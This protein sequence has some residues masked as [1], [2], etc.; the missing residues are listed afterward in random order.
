MTNQK[1]DFEK[2]G[3]YDLRN[4]ARSIGVI[5]PTKFKR[6]ELIQKITAIIMGEE[7][8]KKKTNKGR[9]PKHKLNELSQLDY[10]L[11][12]NLFNNDDPKYK[13][14]QNYTNINIDSECMICENTSSATTNILYDGYYKPFNINYGFVLKKGYL[15][16]Y[17]K[18]NVIILT[19][20]ADK[21]NLKEG[22][23]ISGASS[24]LK[25]KN[26]MLATSI[27]TINNKNAV[28]D[29]I[30]YDQTKL[31]KP[32]TKIKLDSD[33]LID[34]KIIDRLFP[35]AK[36]TRILL[37]FSDKDKVKPVVISMLN[38]LSKLNNI[39][40]FLFTIDDLP[41]EI[42]DISQKCPD[43]QIV[44]YGFDM[45]RSKYI[46]MTK[47]KIRHC[48][49]LVEEGNDV[50]VVCYNTKNCINN[51][52]SNAVIFE[53]LTESGAIKFAQNTM[54]DMFV[55]ARN[56]EHGSLTTIF[57]NSFDED[58]VDICNTNINF[59][60]CPL[61]ETDI[62]TDFFTSFTRNLQDL[63]P[64]KE[65]EKIKKFKCG[66]NKDNLLEKLNQF[67]DNE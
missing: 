37:N 42:Y 7:P 54:K 22:D 13:A 16:D 58:F 23:Y 10:I 5:S 12:N 62:T 66:L 31:V 46:E 20:L 47:V 40:P 1:I 28:T 61:P 14:Y 63:V 6:D 55:V 11:P 45:D 29:R 9:P 25:N 8:E 34:F 48:Y 51:L 17:Y 49:R 44:T 41:E 30:R 21:Y 53:G 15:S 39:T 65:Y 32:S 50:A 2:M 59:N 38:N 3:I 67:F 27:L 33:G 60:C 18:E 52:I 56:C 24:Y 36:G 19:S 4:Y 43:T 57:I 26:L 64:E 35:L